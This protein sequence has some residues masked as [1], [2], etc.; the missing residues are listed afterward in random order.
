[1]LM[2]TYP[3]AGLISCIFA[4]VLLTL[5]VNTYVYYVKWLAISKSF[6]AYDPSP[7]LM[8]FYTVFSIIFSSIGVTLLTIHFKKWNE[9]HTIMN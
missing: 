5:D 3:L 6:F 7:N 4:I 2:K 8:K 1:M 9:K